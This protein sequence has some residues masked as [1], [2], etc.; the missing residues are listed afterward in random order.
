[1]TKGNRHTAAIEL[2]GELASAYPQAFF[3]DRKLRRPLKVG[4]D[5][6]LLAV[7]PGLDRRDLGLTLGIYVSCF[8]YQRA[9]ANGPSGLT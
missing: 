1:M 4:I 6:D 9:L 2:I 7:R 3:S 5:R 8:G